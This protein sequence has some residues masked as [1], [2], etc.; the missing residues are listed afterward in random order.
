MPVMDGFEATEKL[1]EKGY[2]KIYCCIDC[3]TTRRA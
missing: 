3:G 2:E 1:R